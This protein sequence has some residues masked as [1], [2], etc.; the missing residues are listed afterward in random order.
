MKKKKDNTGIEWQVWVNKDEVHIF[1]DWNNALAFV[2]EQPKP[3]C[4]EGGLWY[5]SNPK[6]T[7]VVRH[8]CATKI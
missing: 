3:E 7:K 6:V 1:G 4:H 8:S 2:S 5:P